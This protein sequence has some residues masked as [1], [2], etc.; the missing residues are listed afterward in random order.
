MMEVFSVLV[1]FNNNVLGPGIAG[2]RTCLAVR[3]TRHEGVNH[4][5]T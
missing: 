4:G 2:P 3:P 5:E 1:E